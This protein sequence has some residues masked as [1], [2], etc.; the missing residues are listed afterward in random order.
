M[1]IKT[2]QAGQP[3]HLGWDDLGEYSNSREYDIIYGLICL[4]IISPLMY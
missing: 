2:I 4:P 1:D 3:M